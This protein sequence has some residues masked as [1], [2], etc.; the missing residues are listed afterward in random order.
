MDTV[1]AD[2]SMNKRRHIPVK[3]SHKLI[4]GFY[5]SYI[6]S[7]FTQIFRNFDSDKSSTDNNCRFR[8]M[9]ICIFLE[10]KRRRTFALQNG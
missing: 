2:F 7:E 8:M 4:R 1:F 9:L 3:R 6:Y 5:Q 10:S